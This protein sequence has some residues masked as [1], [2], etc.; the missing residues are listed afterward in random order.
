MTTERLSELQNLALSGKTP[1]SEQLTSE[2][3]KAW[4][5]I[6]NRMEAYEYK[7]KNI[8]RGGKTYGKGNS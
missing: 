1:E 3:A 7:L 2:E 4:E 6:Q 8:L 5:H